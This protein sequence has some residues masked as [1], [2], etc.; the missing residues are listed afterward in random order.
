[1]SY[2]VDPDALSGHRRRLWGWRWSSNQSN[3]HTLLTYSFPTS[4]GLVWRIY[5]H[6]RFRGLQL[7]EQIA[8]ATKI[9]AMYDAVCNVDFAFTSDPASANIRMA[10]ADAVDVGTGTDVHPHRARDCSR[11][12]LRVRCLRKATPGSITTTTT[13]PTLGDFAFASG[14][15]HEIGHALGLKHGHMTQEVQ[16][17]SGGY[18]YTNPALAPDHDSLEYS[19]MTYRSYP[20]GRTDGVFAVEFP[21]TPMQDDI[22][23]LQYLYGPNYANQSG[24]TVYTFSP[25]TGAMS[26]NGVEPGRDLPPQDL[27]DGLGWRRQR[28]L[29]FLQLHDQRDHQS[30]SR[31]VVDAVA[32]ATRRSRPRASR[33][34]FRPRLHR[35]R[36]FARRR[37][38]R[39]YRERDRRL[40]Q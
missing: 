26:I 3:G 5:G 33:P 20:G 29:R 18:L 1:M 14:L 27:P 34:A 21:S 7:A 30:Q 39:L 22:L 12:E 15:M 31:S 9:L 6:L 23:T 17:A 8:A 19:V 25:S 40:R 10:E 16:D 32:G 37:P 4:R 24:N 28:H 11:P 35:Q 38:P 13:T 2:P 36:S